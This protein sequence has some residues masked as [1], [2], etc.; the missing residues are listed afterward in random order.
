MQDW[1]IITIIA[2]SVLCVAIVI[3]YIA[4]YVLIKRA[5]GGRSQAR[6]EEV[7]PSKDVAL[8]GDNYVELYY[9]GRKHAIEFAQFK[10][11]RFTVT[12]DDGLTLVGYYIKS[13]NPQA[14]HTLIAA[15]GFRGSPEGDFGSL[16]KFFIQHFNVMY[17]NHRSHNESEGENIDFSKKAYLDMPKWV[18]KA[19]EFNPDGD[20]VLHGVSM[21]GAIVC[22]ASML[23]LG[24]KVKFIV[25]D[26]AFS[27]AYEQLGHMVKY[28][29][30]PRF[31]F[32][33][34]TGLAFRH[35]TGINPKTIRPID[36]VKKSKYP[37]LFVH[38]IQDRF[39]PF[40]MGEELYSAC[41]S[42]KDCVWV[43]GAGH[44][45]SFFTGMAEYQQKYLE[46]IDKYC[47]K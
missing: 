10:R 41:A 19:Q 1:L 47:T 22:Q 25:S 39:V 30:F 16:C 33:M 8:M 27:D 37:I 15:H 17:I 5:F 42:E 32:K 40:S 23:D 28:Y 2:V 43:Q 45:G 13:P 21:G 6:H 31:P 14:K 3:T 24:D 12:T 26:C 18:E 20:I 38:G 44:G 11:E 9:Y 35:T 36:A 4:C 7:D 29:K 34:L 46:F